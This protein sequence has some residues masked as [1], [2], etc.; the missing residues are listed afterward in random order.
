MFGENLTTRG[1]LEGNVY[2]GDVWEWGEALLQ[3]SQPRSPCYKLATVTGRP[4]VIKRMMQNGRTAW[5]LRLLRPGV[6]P[7]AGPLRLVSRHAAAV[8]VLRVHRLL[9]PAPSDR[10]E[11][12]AIAAV[13][14]LA[15]SWRDGLRQ[16]LMRT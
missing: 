10:S 1:W 16:A 14:E 8:S 6:V 2:I 11:L 15:A 5:Y 7:T 13:D 12:E 3:V 4:D 9:L